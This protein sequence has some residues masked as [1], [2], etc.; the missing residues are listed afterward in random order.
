MGSVKDF[1]QPAASSRRTT[2]KTTIGGGAMKRNNRFIAIA[3][4]L[5][6]VLSYLPLAT[7]VLPVKAQGSV[8]VYEH[9][10]RNSGQKLVALTFDL[11]QQNVGD[12]VWLDTTI[13]DVLAQTGTPATFFASGLFAQQHPDDIRTLVGAG[14]EVEA[15]FWDHPNDG[16][17]QFDQ[18]TLDLNV[19]IG[20]TNDVI[21]GLTGKSP[22]YV[23]LPAGNGL[24]YD[25]NGIS[26]GVV[27][28]TYLR[29]INQAGTSVLDWDV[30]SGDPDVANAQI[31]ISNVQNSVQ[32]GS[33]IV[34]H[35]NGRGVHTAEALQV[36]IPWLKRQGYTLVTVEQ[37]NNLTGLESVLS[38]AVATVEPSIIN[39][40]SV[41]LVPGDG[42]VINCD[43][44]GK[45]AV[46]LDY[47]NWPDYTENIENGFLRLG[48]NENAWVIP[49]N[50]TVSFGEQIGSMGDSI[51]HSLK[52]KSGRL[53][54][55]LGVCD[56]AAIVHYVADINGLVGDNPAQHDPDGVGH[57]QLPVLP[58]DIRWRDVIWQEGSVYTADTTI[59]NPTS[60]DA[61]MRWTI[62]SNVLTIWVEFGGQVS[63]PQLPLLV[64]PTA[65][66]EP[67][68]AEPALYC[69]YSHTS[70]PAD[71]IVAGA[72]VEKGQLIGYSGNLGFGEGWTE[73]EPHTVDHLH[74]GCS[75]TP[76]E[77]IE[78]DLGNDSIW[79]W[80]DPS[81]SKHLGWGD[82]L[83]TMYVTQ[84]F[85]VYNAAGNQP[86]HTGMDL[87]AAYG[88]ELYAVADAVVYY[89]G[90][91]P[92]SYESMKKGNGPVIVLK[93][94]GDSNGIL[95][96]IPANP[97]W[98]STVTELLEDVGVEG[99]PESVKTFS[100]FMLILTITALLLATT[101]V[102]YYKRQNNQLRQRLGEE[103]EYKKSRL[104]KIFW[105][106]TLILLV[107]ALWSKD[108]II[109]MLCSKSAQVWLVQKIR[110]LGKRYLRHMR[111]ENAF[112]WFVD[113]AKEYVLV[114]WSWSMVFYLVG[115]AIVWIPGDLQ[116]SQSVRAQEIIRQTPL[117]LKGTIR[118][119]IRWS[120]PPLAV[121]PEGAVIPAIWDQIAAGVQDE[122]GTL[123]ETWMLYHA[124][125]TEFSGGGNCTE[126]D[127]AACTSY[128]GAQG[129]FQ[130]MP[131]T[132]PDYADP[133]WSK[134]DL[135]QSAR[136]AYRMF[137]KL[138]LFEQTSKYAFQTRFTGED[139]G[140]AWNM[141]SAKVGD[142]DGWEQAGIIWDNY[143]PLLGGGAPLDIPTLPVITPDLTLCSDELEPCGF[144][145]PK[146]PFAY[147]Q[148][149]G[150][151]GGKD[152]HEKA[153]DWWEATK[154]S[155]AD[156]PINVL[157]MLNKA[158]VTEIGRFDNGGLGGGTTYIKI[159]NGRWTQTVYHCDDIYAKPGTTTDRT[160]FVTL[161]Q[162]VQWGQPICLMGNQG[163]SAWT[164][165]HLRLD[166]PN[167]PVQDQ[168]QWWPK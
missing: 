139:G 13:V 84:K 145:L 2:Q 60:K 28:E 43:S 163:Q 156:L 6:V 125:R 121:L 167:G 129:W 103:Q 51:Y 46:R 127:H 152:W 131:G 133:S 102:W 155:S 146:G 37:M 52:N 113:L 65:T 105:W 38:G 26:N 147:I 16:A 89:V 70:G 88:T 79:N 55:A 34:M 108:D 30:V 151:N 138:E 99:S 24:N 64:A 110:D 115:F 80:V 54:P 45:C 67:E 119:P 144:A 36:L 86:K 59:N 162:S 134:Y 23:R 111:L 74:F 107:W 53:I 17:Y 137:K 5:L 75:T 148:G 95:P 112:P 40:V 122:G 120:G 22:T 77:Q 27:N 126:Q 132:W 48:H 83:K 21:E 72:K 56:V 18:G 1:H 8:G 66:P 76:P 47:Y 3:T 92:V 158:T 39:P 166:G 81:P 68:T 44:S 143:Q 61:V 42:G 14:H 116:N 69:F 149:T 49:A 71:G 117:W 10:V 93:I 82:P 128:A 130:F 118:E 20:Q 164:H 32:D 33:I 19:Q 90:W 12:N 114:V 165:L 63:L 31:V 153:W 62:E 91:W 124:Q 7:N 87:R 78:A 140:L 141:K 135:R 73:E 154:S 57:V 58:N 9:G 41:P 161:N 35:G 100:T 123:A 4:L 106:L 101:L 160:S 136:A 25:T 96:N 85:K 50:S 109:W 150:A 98:D 94:G 168:T 104:L 157:S 159:S 97:E 15:H 142:Y 11:C 29:A